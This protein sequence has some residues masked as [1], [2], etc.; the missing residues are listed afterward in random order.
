MGRKKSVFMFVIG[1]VKQAIIDTQQSRK[2]YF[3]TLN[4]Y[5]IRSSH[6]IQPGKTYKRIELIRINQT[7]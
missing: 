1:V 3:D 5:T 2:I 4:I 7:N 6:K